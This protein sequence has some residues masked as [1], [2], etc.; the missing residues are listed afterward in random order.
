MREV[1]LVVDMASCHLHP[2]IPAVARSQGLADGLGTSWVDVHLTASRH[3]RFSAF[4]GQ[5]AGALACLQ[6]QP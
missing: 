5:D 3:S 2:S 1:F 4:P 6:E